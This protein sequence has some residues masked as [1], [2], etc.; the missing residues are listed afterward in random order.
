VKK[1]L[2]FVLV[3]ALI[4]ALVLTACDRNGDEI[5]PDDPY[6]EDV[7]QPDPDTDTDPDPYPDPDSDSVDEDEDV[8]I[9][10]LPR[11]ETL[12]LAGLQWGT[13][14]GWNAFSADMNNAMA[15]DQGGYGSITTMFETLYMFNMLTNEMVPLLAYGL[16][17][18]AE[19][20]TYI[21]VNMNPNALWSDG[22][23]VTA[24][25]MAFTFEMALRHNNSTGAANRP[26]I[27][28]IE[29]ADD[30]TLIIRSVLVDGLPANPLMMREFLSSTYVLQRAWLEDLESRNGGDS[31]AILADPGNDAPSTGPYRPFFWDDTR[32]VLVRDDNYWGQH[33][34]M[35]GRLPAP[36]FL[37]HMVFAD[38]DAAAV[39]LRAGEVDVAQ[40]FIPNVQNMWLIDE[41]PI[42]TFMDQPPFGL[43][44]S[45]PTAY[46]NLNVPGLD[47]VYVRRAIA[48]A[49]DYDAIVANAM[50]NQSPTF[51]EV[52]RSLMNPTAGE[53]AMFDSAAVAHLQWAGN[54]IDGANAILDEIG[55]ER[56]DDGIRVLDG[57][58][59]AFNACAPHGWSDWEAAMEIVAAAG[60]AIGIEITTLFPDWSVYQTVVTAAHQTE[61]HIFMMW[62]DSS[63]PA[64][65]WGRVRQL[66]SSDFINMES[67]W[68]GN[69]GQ[70]Y[71]SRIDEII[72]AIPLEADPARVV[73]LYTEAVY[74]YLSYV[75][76]FSLMYRPAAFHT[77]NESVWTGFTEY[78]DGN[79][80]P[81]LHAT[82]GYGIADLFN[83]RLVNP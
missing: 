32:V 43:T 22:T 54:D 8:D 27:E 50:T 15:I 79:N 66:M 23:P 51:L 74:I 38:N 40:I 16:Y 6:D 42:T 45:I 14:N 48:M 10:L 31:A 24:H 17:V 34:S 33:P 57:V 77:V 12:F 68:S 37:A 1:K 39:A 46:F 36:R 2:L 21:T 29:A 65:P 52:P 73:E 75:P 59:L 25:D 13:V 35:W 28:T 70:F 71:N 64:Q 19:D 18:W 26:F 81:P 67:N 3:L 62:T 80:I 53:Q 78:G 61:Y 11:D 7:V 58:R 20:L 55:A 60:A 72:A 83:I 47:N 76:S 30:H 56:G 49:V 82:T 41:L 5:T 44:S 69:W 63:S 9:H 4:G